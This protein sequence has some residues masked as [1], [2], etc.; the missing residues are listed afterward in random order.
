MFTVLAAAVARHR[1]RFGDSFDTASFDFDFCLFLEPN[2][3]YV[4]FTCPFH[5][6]YLLNIEP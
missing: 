1:Y 4:M 2:L 3:G 6:N 5:I